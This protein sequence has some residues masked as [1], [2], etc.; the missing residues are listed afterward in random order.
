M[1]I[2]SGVE[3]RIPVSQKIQ[4]TWYRLKESIS[5]DMESAALII[6]HAGAGSCLEALSASKSLVVVVN[7]KLMGNHQL[8]LAN[9]LHQEGH[10]LM[11]YPENLCSTLC[12]LKTS[13]FKQLPKANQVAFSSYIE[14]LMG[15]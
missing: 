1:Q 3:P 2:G 9:K 11:C 7:Q 4:I 13:N 10:A 15:L 5:A 8:E 14:S 6:S 12:N